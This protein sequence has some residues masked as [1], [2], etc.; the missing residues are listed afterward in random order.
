M[1]S[2]DKSLEANFGHRVK[3]NCVV[4]KGFNEDELCNFVALTK[5]APLDVRFIEYMP[6]DGNKW[7]DRKMMPFH[8]MLKVI[9]KQYPEIIRL[10]P[11][12][13]DT[14]KAYKVAGFEGQIGFITSMSD[15]FCGS[16]NRLRVT[17]DGNLKV[18]AG[19]EGVKIA[20]E[21]AIHHFRNR[22]A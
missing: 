8:E 14:A 7:S 6:F 18:R 22:F 16:C 3:I 4:M 13:N 20:P 12:L 5:S 19:G 9:E 15:N 11:E 1:Q 10:E 17:A 21:Q 2:I